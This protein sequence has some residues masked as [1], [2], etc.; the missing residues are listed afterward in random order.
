[1]GARA[2]AIAER[3]EYARVIGDYARGLGRLVGE[4]LERR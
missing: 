3:F 1:M 4:E 2:R